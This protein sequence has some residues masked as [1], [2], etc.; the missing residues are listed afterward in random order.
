MSL[1]PW[2]C[3]IWLFLGYFIISIQPIRFSKKSRKFD[4]ERITTDF[5]CSKLDVECMSDEVIFWV[6]FFYQQYVNFPIYFQNPIID[7]VF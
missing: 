2:L 5:L 4:Y 7:Y 6:T 3:L 1:R